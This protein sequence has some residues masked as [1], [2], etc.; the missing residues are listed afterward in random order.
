M[1][2]WDTLMQN[3]DRKDWLVI[4]L[5]EGK[6]YEEEH[7]P[8]A[9]HQDQDDLEENIESIFK[10]YHP[11]KIIL[12]CDRGNVSLLLAR[13]LGQQGYPVV[14]LGGGYRKGKS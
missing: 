9:I 13:D 1:I 4:D 2:S 6:E 7:F 11:S 14:S 10:T 3:K 12:Y 8:G 5:R